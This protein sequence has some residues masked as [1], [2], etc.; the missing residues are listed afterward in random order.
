[1]SELP[2]STAV[3]GGLT[4]APG[5]PRL[6]GASVAAR[7][8]LAMFSIALLVHARHLTG[9]FAVA[10]AVTGAYA[11]AVGVG[12]P[13]LGRVVDRR[14]QTVPLVASAA[15][16]AVLLGVLALLPSGTAAPAI[17]GLAALVGLATPPVGACARGLLPEL[18]DG[19]ALRSAYAFESSAVELTF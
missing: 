8:P 13:L 17:V 3:R 10:G 1:M 2:E 5:V 6:L 14:G 16:A 7:L 11:A 12:G 9:S 19:D 4:A 15:L 18:M